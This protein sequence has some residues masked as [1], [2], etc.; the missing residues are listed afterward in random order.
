MRIAAKSLGDTPWYLRP[1]FWNQRRKYGSVLDAALLWARSPRLFL[2]VAT[3]YGMIDRKSSPLEP[4]LRSLVTVRVSQINWCRFCVDLNSATLLKCGTSIDKL[5]ALE[6]WR[7]SALFIEHERAALEYA[8]AMTRSDVRV[9]ADLIQKLQT[10]FQ[11]D[12]IIE[13]TGLIAFQNMSSKFN[14]AL[15]VP[16][17]G[18]CQVPEISSEPLENKTTQ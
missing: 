12:T 14:A 8:E 2:G 13:L 9:G 5:K 15:D 3:L 11:D 16:P 6:N 1:F 7:E 18:F 10:H 4:A 17:R